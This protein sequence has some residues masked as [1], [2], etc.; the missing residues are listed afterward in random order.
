MI[1]KAKESAVEMYGKDR[2]LYI[3]IPEG[4]DLPTYQYVGWFSSYTPV[5]DE[6]AFGSHLVVIWWDDKQTLDGAIDFA[7]AHWGHAKDFDI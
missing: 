1:D 2:P 7:A 3:A 4:N 5:N 6:D